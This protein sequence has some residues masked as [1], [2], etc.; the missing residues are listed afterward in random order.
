[1]IALVADPKDKEGKKT[2]IIG[3]YVPMTFKDTHKLEKDNKVEL[4]LTDAPFGF[5]FDN[6]DIKC[7]IYKN[8]Q[9]KPNFQSYSS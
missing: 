2:K 9:T 5:Y 4:E 3:M 6:N 1:M 7:L 8:Q